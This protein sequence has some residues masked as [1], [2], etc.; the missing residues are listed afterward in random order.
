MLRKVQREILSQ[1]SFTTSLATRK[2]DI[3]PF[4]SPWSIDFSSEKLELI[5]II[6]KEMF[7]RSICVFFQ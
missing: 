7:F 1:I 2:V 3:T 6:I 4:P 5:L